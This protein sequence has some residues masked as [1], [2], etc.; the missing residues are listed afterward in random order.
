MYIFFRYAL[1]AA[2][3]AA[4]VLFITEDLTAQIPR[5]ADAPKPL[6]PEESQQRFQL[7]PG[8]HIE[9]VASEPLL[10]DPSAILI[11]HQGR[12][13]VCELHGYNLEG[14]L[15][16]VELNKTGQL[17][18]EVRR[19]RVEGDML[20]EAKQA[21]TGTVKLLVDDDGDGRMDDMRV[22]ASDLP[23]CYGMVA[24]R[25]GLIVICGP[26][27]V[28]L[29]DR[30]GDGQAEVRETLLTGFDVEVMERAINN[31]LWGLDNWVYVATGNSEQIAT[32]PNL[33]KEVHLGRTDFRFHP[34]GTAIEAVTGASG[35]FG[36]AFRDFGDRFLITTTTPSLYAVPLPRR[37][38]L[39]NPYVPSPS[40][41]TGASGYNKNYPTSEPHPWRAARGTDPD[42]VKFYGS[43]EATPNGN[44]TSGCSP[45]AYRGDA[46]PA[47][48]VGNHFSCDPSNNLVHRAVI[49]RDGSRYRAH[50]AAG[51]EER[52]FLSSADTWCRPMNLYVGPD[53]ALYVVD[54]YREIIEDYSA[55]P[56][57]LQQQYG[58]IEGDNHGRIWR[59]VH[60]SSGPCDRPQ[61][62]QASDEEL[63]DHLSHTNAWWRENAQR[64]LIE[65]NATSVQ[66][67]IVDVC[68]NG[69]TPQ[70][71]V[72]ALYT[73]DGMGRLDAQTAR[74]ALRDSHYG[75]RHHGLRLAEQWIN[76]DADILSIMA[77]MTQDDDPQVR[78]QL[79]MSL[80]ESDDSRSLDALAQLATQYGNERWMDA[81][82]MSSVADRAH[83]LTA[84]LLAAD[85]LTAGSQTLLGPLAACV[86]ARR[87]RDELD[88]LL[89]AIA[90]VTGAEVHATQITVLAGIAEGLKRGQGDPVTIGDGRK[91]MEQ[92]WRSENVE[93][94]QLAFGLAVQL[95][96][97]DSEL[98]LSA[99]EYSRHV[100]LDQQ[101]QPAERITAIELLANA[102]WDLRKPLTALLV[103]REGPEIQVA[104]VK[105]MATN[106]D[107]PVAE[108]LLSNWSGLSI[109]GQE[110]V[111]DA[112]FG[113]PVWLPQLLDAVEKG[114][115]LPTSISAL[116]KAQL[117]ET[118][119]TMLRER[120]QLLLGSS[121]S[122]ER[123]KVVARYQSALELAADP[124]RGRLLFDKHCAQCHRLENRGFA[125][126]PELSGAVGRPD[127]TLIGDILDPSGDIKP[128]YA[129]YTVYMVDGRATT[130]VLAEES[131][132]SVTI[133]REKGEQ[134]TVLR[135]DI[136]EMQGSSKSMMPEG[137]EKEVAPQDVA[138]LIGYLR[139]ALGP[140][141]PTGV[142]L[143]DEQRDFVD[144][145]TQGGGTAE[146]WSEDRY[147]GDVCLRITPS[148]RAATQM[149]G[150]DFRI[151]KDPRPG[152]YRYLRLRWKAPGT[153]GALVELAAAGRWPPAE[154]PTRRYYAG[155]NTTPWQAQQ[156]SP[157]VPD[158]WSVVTVDLYK[159]NGEF[160][161]TGFAP[162]AMGGPALFDRVELLRALDEPAAPLE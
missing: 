122:G 159:D 142:V 73:L 71:R 8:F 19:V 55:I 155:E 3:M 56:R 13:F 72:H 115:I 90:S 21:R 98:M 105:A 153:E 61:L 11:D 96:L 99:L 14:H 59:V 47:D 52:E 39:R 9:L 107:G 146:V 77:G 151:V 132:T 157:H 45:L 40:E 26:D 156:V 108:A 147:S 110:A 60:E 97:E 104:A 1:H 136:E 46:F 69:K 17:D 143:F 113:R 64:L 160:T 129:V 127:E 101:R 49:E 7:R 28:Y 32:G 80:G 120:A 161:L 65:R 62:N 106:D 12:F 137:F 130:G 16:I 139:L 6:T 44:F 145:F 29:A 149:R 79:A 86:G 87:Q 114:T 131:A 84:R 121:T 66:E 140:A 89:L 117:L 68:R 70:G 41:S 10:A 78:L 74:H 158:E 34:D 50:R 33:A 83:Q 100:A 112:V 103:T 37:Y 25:D 67:A 162:T 150:W 38:L 58:L 91:A 2:A 135:K 111:T 53:G 15:D 75:V 36:H 119:D 24:Y 141:Q 133:R 30:D 128:G 92:L 138:D 85:E 124:Q 42:W 43:R 148:Q 154:S 27:I 95:G 126:G 144:Q 152:E 5:A 20:E 118:G 4:I 51:E 35:T 125:V 48:F 109:D 82:I 22:W 31:P 23:P 123:A 93:V 134:D 116:R 81:A 76:T 94:I 88:G 102:Q 57:Y 18:R 54:I 63:V